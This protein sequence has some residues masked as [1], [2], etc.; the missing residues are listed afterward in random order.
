MFW[1]NKNSQLDD[2]KIGD[3][4]KYMSEKWEIIAKDRYEWIPSGNSVEY[5]LKSGFDEM[6][7]EVEKEKDQWELTLTRKIDLGLDEMKEALE[8]KEFEYQGMFYELEESY[9]GIFS[10]ETNNLGRERVEEFV[11]YSDENQLICIS[12]WGQDD[13]EAHFGKEISINE[14]KK[15]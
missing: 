10:S 11:F 3:Q 8:N 2:W 7:L 14:I 1:K 15:K 5:T 13:Y 12:Y 4:I 6:F 9:K